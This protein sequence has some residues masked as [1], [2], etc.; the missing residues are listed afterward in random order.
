M[1]EDIKL[2]A[3]VDTIQTGYWNPVLPQ[4][5]FETVNAAVLARIASLEEENI[6]LHA[7][8][9]DTT[10]GMVTLAEVE[11]VVREAEKLH[12]V[13]AYPDEAVEFFR[14]CLAPKQRSRQRAQAAES[15]ARSANEKI[16]KKWISKK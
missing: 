9:A 16:F 12:Y 14:A 8:L 1:T 11:K 5:V 10:R 13:S 6:K 15:A 2:A 3:I 4:G 7:Q